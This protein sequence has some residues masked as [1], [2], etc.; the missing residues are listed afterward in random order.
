MFFQTAA[1]QEG[2]I[3][4]LQLIAVD[5]GDDADP[6]AGIVAG[7]WRIAVLVQLQL[8]M[9][10]HGQAGDFL[11]HLH[12]LISFHTLERYASHTR[13]NTVWVWEQAP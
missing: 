8:F 1:Q 5:A 13:M 9:H 10:R 3:L 2:H 4:P 6:S 11:N 7:P 12:F